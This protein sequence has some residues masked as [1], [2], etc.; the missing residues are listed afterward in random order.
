MNNNTIWYKKGIKYNN[1]NC[2]EQFVY[3]PPTLKSIASAKILD[4]DILEFDIINTKFFK[5][6]ATDPITVIKKDY[7]CGEYHYS[8]I[9]DKANKFM[10]CIDIEHAYPY[11][12]NNKSIPIS[13]VNDI[14]RNER[15]YRVRKQL[16]P[17]F[18]G[19]QTKIE[20]ID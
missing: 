17:Y 9:T 10:Y 3:Q 1:L 14:A 16:L 20:Y 12:D 13:Q 11:S 5:R 8:K 15:A 7:S 18:K 4:T 2:T 6:I 19:K